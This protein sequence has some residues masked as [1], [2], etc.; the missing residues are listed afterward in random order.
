MLFRSNA[1]EAINLVSY[2]FLNATLKRARGG[3]AHDAF[4]L[5]EGDEI[6]VTEMEHHAN[7]VP[8]QQTAKATGAKLRYIPLTADGRLDA[9]HFDRLITGKTIGI[10][11]V[12]SIA[13]TVAPRCKAFDMTVIGISSGP[14]EVPGFD[15]MV[16]RD[17]LLEA[18]ETFALQLF[19]A[20]GAL[21]TNAITTTPPPRKSSC[22]VTK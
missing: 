17:D 20:S 1:T 16:H 7:I 4:V 12:G 8:W 19:N 2:A 22:R 6:V 14:R 18:N 15:R 11:G 21:I 9:S 10:F 3:E 5:S 13:K